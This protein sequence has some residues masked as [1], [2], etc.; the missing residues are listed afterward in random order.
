[1]KRMRMNRAEYEQLLISRGKETE[2]KLRDDCDVYRIRVTPAEA[3]EIFKKRKSFVEDKNFVAKDDVIV[4]GSI[5]SYDAYAIGHGLAYEPAQQ[6]F[7]ILNE[8][9]GFILFTPIFVD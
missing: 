3:V 8:K 2:G 6:A 5:K 9:R 4:N 1:M 7:T